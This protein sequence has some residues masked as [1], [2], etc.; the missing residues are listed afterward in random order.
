[1]PQNNRTI[2]CD[3]CGYSEEEEDF[4][5]GFPGWAIIK[6]IGACGPEEGQPVKNMNMETV[7][8][9]QCK[10]EIALFIDNMQEKH[11]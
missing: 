10:N 9:P 4:G 2:S 1:M 3:V 7:L 6:G 8:C 5:T 11:K